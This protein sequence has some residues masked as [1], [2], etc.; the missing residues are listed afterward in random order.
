MIKVEKPLNVLLN[1]PL[2]VLIIGSGGREHA[3]CRKISHS[4]HLK[5]LFCLPGNPGTESIAINLDGSVS[6]FAKILS[7]VKEH[8]ID[9]TIVG[10][11]APLS[12][13]IVDLFDE[14]Q[15]PIIGPNQAAARLESSKVFAKEFCTRFNL[16]TAAYQTFSSFD[17]AVLYIEKSEKEEH[18]V[19]VDGLA[20][21]KGVYVC[22][23][24]VAALD[25]LKEIFL[26]GKFGDSGS[27]VIIEEL[28][29]GQELSFFA[30]SD[31]KTAIPLEVAQDYKRLLDGQKGPNTG[32]M[33]SYAPVEWVSDDFKKKMFDSI[34]VPTISGMNDLGTP[35]KGILFMGL[36]IEG[37]NIQVLEYNVRFGDPETQ[38]I[39]ELLESDLLE[40]FWAQSQGSLDSLPALKW[41]SGHSICVVLSSEGYPAGP[42]KGDDING[43]EKFDGKKDLYTL[44]AGTGRNSEGNIVTNGGRVVNIC[45][46][47][48]ESLDSVRN[49]VYKAIPEVVWKGMYY[50]RD[51]GL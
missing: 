25:A 32:G 1:E 11:E 15:L 6:D 40:V 48:S 41:K 47:H 38:A 4:P 2:N 21:G 7:L 51:I 23:S 3:I 9:L 16:P 13:G 49:K 43:L 14:H 30:L 35:F 39:L 24:K 42:R 28:L 20:A 12:Q 10:P 29:T 37:E 27:Q 22:Q 34:V 31:G 33:G 45:A 46:Y 44:H 36:M 18:V 8:K 19:K 5:Q 26:E 17:E 50:R